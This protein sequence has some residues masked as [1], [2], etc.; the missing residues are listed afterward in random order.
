MSAYIKIIRPVN[1]LIIILTQVLFRFFIV[2]NYFGLGGAESGFNY[3]EFMILVLATILI[4]AG[5][6]VINDLYDIKADEVN[7]PEKIIAGVFISKKTL[8]FYYA[9]LTSTGVLL[10][11]LLAFRVSFLSLGLIFPAIAIMLWL[12]SSEYQ[13]TAL[14]GNLMIG[15]M[16]G[17]VVFIVWL[18]EFFAMRA[19]PLVYAAAAQTLET[20]GLI[21]GAY[22]V[23]ASLV[24]LIRE[25]FKDIEDMEGDKAAGYRTLPLAFGKSA[26][27]ITA[28]AFTVITIGLLA[29]FQFLL[30]RTGLTLVF[31]YLMIA[32]QP[33]LL[34]L[35]Y[36]TLKAKDK[37]DF[38]FVSNV[39][40]IIMLAGILSMQ[41]FYISY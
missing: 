29:S 25:I 36:Y 32:V 6:Y 9:A 17:L 7:K 30:F 14:L 39:S 19:Q 13:H 40:K 27:K 15:L 31:W 24:T 38:H 23:F 37:E 1:L 33:L 22:A 10:G 16:S 3:I 8:K 26:A 20:I 11:V 4:A 28:M 41:L 21:A 35:L 5:G 18:F 34:F 2:D 12:Y